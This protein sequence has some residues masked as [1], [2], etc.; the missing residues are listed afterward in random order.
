MTMMP[1]AQAEDALGH[2]ARRFAHWR[3]GR[4]TPRGRIPKP[5]WEQAVSL[6]QVLPLS[7]VAKQLGLGSH[8][9]KKRGGGKPHTAGSA[10]LPTPLNFV[11]VSP[12]SVWR[13]STTEVEIHR[14]DGARLRLTYGEANPALAPLVKTFLESC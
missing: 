14:T 9:L 6:T 3:Q 2:L 4:T 11:E 5:L 1:P 12:A 13:P 10:A 8:A 7:R